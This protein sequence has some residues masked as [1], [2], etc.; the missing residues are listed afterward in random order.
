M[1]LLFHVTT[2]ST[3]LERTRTRSR[4]LFKMKKRRRK[5]L[6]VDN[7]QEFTEKNCFTSKFKFFF[8]K[9]G[10]CVA[11]S[12]RVFIRHGAN[13]VQERLFYSYCLLHRRVHRHFLTKNDTDPHCNWEKQISVTWIHEAVQRKML[14][15]GPV[16]SIVRACTRSIYWIVQHLSSPFVGQ[17]MPY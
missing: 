15:V 12:I 3:S 17:P 5:I 7:L 16:S 11:S 9:K 6:A 2:P 8:A 14:Q 4:S 10:E 13:G 1:L